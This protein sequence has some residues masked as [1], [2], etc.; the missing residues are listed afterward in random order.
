M[1]M[2]HP[3]D[4]KVNQPRP[5]ADGS[6]STE[7]T[8]TVQFPDGSWVNVPSLWWG[9]GQ[10]VKDFGPMSDDQLADFAMRYEMTTGSTFPRYGSL[11]QAESEAAARSR[12]GG[13]ESQSITA[14]MPPVMP[15]PLPA[16]IAAA[17]QAPR[18]MPMPLPMP[19][20]MSVARALMAK[21]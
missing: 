6:V 13:G 21:K 3:F 7:L 11:D 18:I 8:R 15:R 14:R 5:N 4:P 2:L 16:S 10:N 17:Q 19:P 20:R 1:A 12:A 9:D